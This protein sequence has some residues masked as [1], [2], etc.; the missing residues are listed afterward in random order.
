MKILITDSFSVTS[1]ERLKRELDCELV[2]SALPAPSG[3]EI[4]GCSAALIRSR[5][6]VSV[7]FLSSE[8]KVIVTATSGFDHIDL[9]SCQQR[10]VAVGYTPEANVISAAEHTLWMM[11][12]CLK[13]PL[14]TQKGWK[15]E[16]RG[17]DLAGL[18][19][20]IIG[21]GRIGR[22]V[23]QLGQ[24]LGM[25]VSAYDPY[26]EDHIFSKCKVE[27]VGLTELLRQSEVLSLHV[28]LTQETKSIINMQTLN[29][30]LPECVLI[31]T[32]RGSVVQ[33]SDL[34]VAIRN[35]KIA[36]AALDVF[37][38]EPLPEDSQLRN[39]PGIFLSPHS[40]AYTQ[41]AF[42]R[43]SVQAV[44]SVIQY[45]RHQQLPNPLP[46]KEPWYSFIS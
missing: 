11:L 17:R 2:R 5:T 40:A 42:E 21:L 32:S 45:F 28:P 25:Q 36:A 31:N 1:L 33:E 26:L 4:F 10:K 3:S 29:L 18:H 12:T 7:D 13:S 44:D 46:P 22:R 24:L 20:G 34:L 15:S 43:S 39:C 23:A 35:K 8:L 19:L 6:K 30:M 38:N 16:T 37:E 27:R 41:Q 14:I 9:M